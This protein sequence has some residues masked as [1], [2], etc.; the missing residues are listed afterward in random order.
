MTESRPQGWKRRLLG[1]GIALAGGFILLNIL[2]Y[3]TAYAMM[4]FQA[5]TTRTRSP[6]ALGVGEKM[7]V[8]FWGVNIPRPHSDM[9]V[10]ALGK[11][12]RSLEI[13]GDGPVRLGAWYCPASSNS[14]LVILFH[15]YTAE[16]SVMIGPAKV[17]LEL[18]CSVLLVDFRGSGESSESYS[19]IGYVEAEDVAAAARYAQ[20]NL[21]PSRI[22]LYGES[23]GGAAVL[24]A[25]ACCGVKPD[26]IVVEAIFDRLLNTMRHRFEAMKTPSF[27]GA[28]LLIF[29]GG[30]QAGFN[31]FKH[32]PVEYARSVACPVLFLH[33]AAD[34][35]ARVAEA[36][37]VFEA[38]PGRKQFKEF[39]D[40]GHSG[41]LDRF[42][43]E[44]K[45]EVG[46]FLRRYVQ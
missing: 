15:G 24:R 26:A 33:G 30:I 7:K 8:L 41:M 20:R 10:T 39:P 29:W 5:D 36:R 3:R 25:I 31:G 2:A 43:D 42:P 44:W 37:R 46:G 23:M 14:P 13:T 32:N 40:V 9:P 16:K 27:P 28:E 12:A 6:E 11:A 34:P 35:R 38:V 18:G 4:H 17:F 19:T 1:L 45:Q 21:S 22:I